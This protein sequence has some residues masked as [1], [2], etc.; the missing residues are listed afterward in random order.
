MLFA[1]EPA[2]QVGVT[3]GQR[4]AGVPH[5]NHQVHLVQVAFEL[6]LRLGDM[7]WIPLNRG[8]THGTTNTGQGAS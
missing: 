3:S 7:A 4:N 2:V 8:S 1:L 5:L 6:L